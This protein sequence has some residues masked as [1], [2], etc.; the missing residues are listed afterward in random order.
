MIIPNAIKLQCEEIVFVNDRWIGHRHQCEHR[1][2]IQ[3]EHKGRLQWR[4]GTHSLAAIAKR[5]SK[6]VAYWQEEVDRIKL[7]QERRKG[8]AALEAAK[9]E[10]P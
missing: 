9:E 1:A 2:T 7:D 4:C 5:K 10:T 8:E 3:E 6:R